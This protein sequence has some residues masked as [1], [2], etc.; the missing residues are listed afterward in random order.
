MEIKILD[1]NKRSQSELKS[2]KEGKEICACVKYSVISQSKWSRMYAREK[3]VPTLVGYKADSF[4]IHISEIWLA[5][6]NEFMRLLSTLTFNEN[7]PVMY[8]LNFCFKFPRL[9]CSMKLTIL[10]A[11]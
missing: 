3:I 2:L 10:V 6:A 4:S 5:T 8:G 7:V 1:P 11:S 9:S